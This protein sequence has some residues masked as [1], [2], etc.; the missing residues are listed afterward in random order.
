M[1]KA[2]QRSS[3]G[4]PDEQLLSELL[5]QVIARLRSGTELSLLEL[6]DNRPELADELERMLPTLKIMVLGLDESLSCD[7]ATR[8]LGLDRGTLGDFAILRELGRG[9]M[10]V[11]YEA[12][13]L[14]LGRRVA[15]KVLPFAAMLDE[16]QLARFK[17]EAQ[18]A[19][20]LKHPGIVNV[21]CVGVERG[22]HFYAMELIEGQSLAE[23]ITELRPV[24]SSGLPLPPGE[25]RGEGPKGS[26][27]RTLPSAPDTV[28][29]AADSTVREPPG[30]RHFRRVAEL[31]IQAA[32]A[33]E[34]AHQRGVI[35]RD[36]KPSNLLVDGAGRLW[37]ADFGLAQIAGGHEL[38]M[39]GD[40]VGTLRYM[41]PEQ[42]RGERL[43]D[44]RTDVYSLG[45]TLFELLTGQPAFAA[46][47]RQHLLRQILETEPHFPRQ[48]EQRIP[49]D[50]ETIVLKCLSKA[51][52]DR[53]ATAQALADD[54][55]RFVEQKP[56]HARPL[57][58]LARAWRWCRRTPAMAGLGAAVF[59][60]ALL[61]SVAS[62]LVALRER[63]HRQQ[64]EATTKQARWQLYLSDMHAAMAAWD[65]ANVGR[66]MTLLERHRPQPGEPDQ[67][68]FEWYHLWKQ[69]QPGLATPTIRVGASVLTVAVSPDGRLLATGDTDRGL[70]LWDAVELRLLR[71]LSGPRKNYVFQVAFS[72]DGRT[73]AGGD[74]YGAIRLWDVATG[75]E[76]HVLSGHADQVSGIQFSPDGR[77]LA[78]A[79]N[80]RTAKLWDLSTGKDYA[81]LT[82]D[83]QVSSVSWTDAQNV[84]TSSRD[85]IV[86]LWNA[87]TGDPTRVLARLPIRTGVGELSHDRSRLA[88]SYMDGSVRL[89]DA[90]EGTLL[91]TLVAHRLLI[92][93]LAY[94][95]DDQ[96]L[97][98]AGNDRQVIL[99]DLVT[100]R[101]REV[102]RGHSGGVNGLAFFPDGRRLASASQDGTVR[103]WDLARTRADDSVCRGHSY[104]VL[105][106]AFDRTGQTLASSSADGTVR[107]WNAATGEPLHVLRGN[108]KWVA[109][110]ACSPRDSV[111]A[112]SGWDGSVRLWDMVT[113]AAL[114]T[115]Q[116]HTDKAYSVAFAPDG[117]R[118]ASAG[119]SD[120]RVR[121]WDV[122]SGA[123]LS[124]FALPQPHI[125]DIA[126]SPDGTSLAVS[127]GEGV[128]TILDATSGRSVRTID[129]SRLNKITYSPDGRLL[130]TASSGSGL[131]RLLDAASGAELQTLTHG[132]DVYGLA[133][134]P[135]GETLATAGTDSAVRLWDVATGEERAALTGHLHEI[136]GVAFSPDGHTLATGS[137]DRTIRLWRA[138][139]PQEAR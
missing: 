23:V 44:Q 3:S 104:F 93:R 35:H 107:L 13:Q 99:W 129:G 63:G 110:V 4:G 92:R 16:R 10:G 84:V 37:V 43:L 22:V 100:R 33:L 36:I 76:V 96:T 5:D 60:L 122:R 9:G 25:G 133:F 20:L 109:S 130:V 78:S 72:P 81:S 29:A 98:S 88:F 32:Q 120:G 48:L 86:R 74:G 77:Y 85:G 90:Q 24:G 11:V 115:V 123:E 52:S 102:L 55:Q 127:N 65:D 124:T 83:E 87:R 67:R 64:A 21:Y 68:R 82:L 40:L 58:R 79:S 39:A 117:R 95:P 128:A 132:A 34:Y 101:P 46:I 108:T 118:I 126:Y 6:T 103:I 53:Y 106:V 131:V 1:A 51:P 112:A 19:A 134:S 14:S 15:L 12:E 135:D 56:I 47:D 105:D 61:V 17:H 27:E 42:A 38:T 2:S 125:T 119:L 94:S 59:C 8:H 41:S 89:L 50:L 28:V 54:L 137:S 97:A 113:G 114:W 111:V 116:A 18:A 75:S 121:L 80:D 57:G 49:V 69:C 71:V 31:G 7:S 30:P 70:L 45:A 62:P 73:V 138:A 91:D 136:C 26:E 139:T 66:V